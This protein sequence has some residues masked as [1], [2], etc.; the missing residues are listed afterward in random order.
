M[1]PT[2][3]AV[4]A[5]AGS[6][7]TGVAGIAVDLRVLAALGAHGAPVI[8]ANTAQQAEGGALNPVAPEV[9]DRQLAAAAQLA[10]AVV[11]TGLLADA[12]QIARVAEFCTQT[13][14][15]LVCDPV[16]RSSADMALTAADAPAALRATLLPRVALLT[17]N[18]AE[19]EALAGIAIRTAVDVERA[20][21]ALRAQGAAAVLI[22]GGHGGGDFS[23]DYFTGADQTFWLHSP[24]LPAANRRGTGCALASAAAGALALGYG[25]ADAVVIAKA[26]INQGLRQGYACGGRE[27]PVQIDRFPDGAG[28][29]PALTPTGDY[30]V[31]TPFPDC[32]TP[33]LGLYPVVDRAAWLARL[34]PQGVTTIQLRVKDLQGAALRAEIR[35]AIALARE[36]G[37]RLFVNDHWQLAMEEGAYGVHLGQEDLRVA[38]IEALRAAGLRLGISTHCHHE[39]AR[40]HALRPSYVAC[41][42]IYETTA[43]AMP[44]VPHGLDGLRY[45]RRLFAGYPLVAIG[46]ID[47]ARTPGVAATGVD[48]VAMISGITQHADPEGTA[49]LLVDLLDGR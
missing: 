22:K 39:A 44:W 21:A 10:P 26:A 17:P 9:L 30:R 20:A 33:R 24:R 31:P 8:T 49:R 2:R 16:L 28:D 35:A 47:A 27:G 14:A 32:N 23:S 6:E 15:L 43:K 29:L 36:H 38:D 48:G 1:N 18:L 34:L 11:K 5:I 7:A 41:G 37:A 45:W 25:L 46:G 19:A 12:G 3:P 4:V 13:G 42:P 40:A